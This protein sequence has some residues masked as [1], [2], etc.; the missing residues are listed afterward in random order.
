MHYKPEYTLSDEPLVSVVIANYNSGKKLLRAVLSIINQSYKKFECI[1]VDDCSTDDSLD[2][3]SEITDERLVIV[4]LK[5][6]VGSY[7]AANAGLDIARGELIARLDA[8]DIS[9]PNRLKF[10]VNEFRKNPS[11]ILLGGRVI[12]TDE[13]ENYKET[14]GLGY[15][16]FLTF[17]NMLV[18]NQF[19]HSTMMF[20]SHDPDGNKIKYNESR[21]ASD[22]VLGLELM[23]KGE[24]KITDE[25]LGT[26]EEGES[27]ITAKHIDKQKETGI[28]ARLNIFDK[29]DFNSAFVRRAVVARIYEHLNDEKVGWKIVDKLL[30]SKDKDD[31]SALHMNR[32][33]YGFIKKSS[34]PKKN[35]VLYLYCRYAPIKN[36]VTLVGHGVVNYML[37][38]VGKDTLKI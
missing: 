37:K 7:S 21:I 28:K 38:K 11:L 34:Y 22:Y 10:Q 9:F 14:I 19:W 12:K 16:E 36:T 13:S 18:R 15:D 4:R 29:L 32:L 17:S 8:D 33:C 24:V 30:E 25:I 31:W 1:V 26:W 27:N 3:L 23:F 2:Y 6:N 5:E 35:K 20:R